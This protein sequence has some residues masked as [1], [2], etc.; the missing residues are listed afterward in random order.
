MNKLWG[1]TNYSANIILAL[2]IIILS[3]T[4]LL[5]IAYVLIGLTMISFLAQLFKDKNSHNFLITS[6]LILTTCFLALVILFKKDNLFYIAGSV[7]ILWLIFSFILDL[8]LDW[9]TYPIE[10]FF[11]PKN[12]FKKN[13]KKKFLKKNIIKKELKNKDN[14]KDYD[15][16]NSFTKNIKQETLDE[17][18]SNYDLE[19]F[20][21]KIVSEDEEGND[22]FE[23]QE[24]G[25]KI[26]LPYKLFTKKGT[27]TLHREDCRTLKNIKISDL[28]EIH[29][30]EEA[31]AYDLKPCKVCK[32][33]E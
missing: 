11:S 14:K 21:E 15:K 4:A 9:R 31:Q 24:V 29:S 28:V 8:S 18:F 7:Y 6:N 25:G 22:D 13:N 32:P 12:S 10:K 2:A 1:I 23:I 19:N 20:S 16:N 17:D 27:I 30:M 5:A 26:E 33:G 3:E